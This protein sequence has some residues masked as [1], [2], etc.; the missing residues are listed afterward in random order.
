MFKFTEKN[1]LIINLIIIRNLEK[2]FSLEVD[3]DIFHDLVIPIKL[4]LKPAL[5][6][7]ETYTWNLSSF[8]FI[9]SIIIDH[10]M[11][12]LSFPHI[13]LFS[14]ETVYLII[15]KLLFKKIIKDIN[16]LHSVL[17][18]KDLVETS[19]AVYD[20]KTGLS[21]SSSSWPKFI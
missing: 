2:D 19:I 3:T 4:V 7:S 13:L 15:I 11:S 8:L 21:P 16:I 12:V 20:G 9:F 10:E 1:N 6:N 18:N 5:Y 14:S 17:I